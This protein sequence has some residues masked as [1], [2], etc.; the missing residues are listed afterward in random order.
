MQMSWW[1]VTE[2]SKPTIRSFK[3]L[4]T[5]GFFWKIFREFSHQRRLKDIDRRV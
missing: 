1:D 3:L 2:E 4:Y 5:K